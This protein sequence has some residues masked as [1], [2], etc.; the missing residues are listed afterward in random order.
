MAKKRKIERIVRKG[1]FKEAGEMDIEHYASL[2]WKK[3]IAIVE[4]MRK[5]FWG[6]KYKSG[7]VKQGATAGLK[8]DRDDFE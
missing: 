1:S 5:M 8:D 3:S 6:K 4:E 2:N 7:M